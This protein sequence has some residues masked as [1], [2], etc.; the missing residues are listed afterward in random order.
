M[1]K[2]YEDSV[3]S[4][5]KKNGELLAQARLAVHGTTGYPDATF[6]LRLNYG[7]VKGWEENGREVPR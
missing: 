2:R 3:E 6:T 4:V 1:R 7:V 5:L